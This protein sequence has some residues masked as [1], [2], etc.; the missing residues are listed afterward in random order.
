VQYIGALRSNKL[1]ILH[2]VELLGAKIKVKDAKGKETEIESG[3][4][5]E[6]LPAVLDMFTADAQ[7]T[8]PGLI[9][10]NTASAA[11]LQTIPGIDASMAE[12]I[13]ST[14]HGLTPD[15]RR[16]PA[17]I[18]QE[19]LV[20]EEVFKQAAPYLTTRTWQFSFYVVGYG[21]P[22]GRYRVLEV[23]IDTA[24]DEPVVTYLRDI[25]K[26]GLPFPLV[27]AAEE[28]VSPAGSSLTSRGVHPPASTKSS[29]LFARAKDRPGAPLT[30]APRPDRAGH[31][32]LAGS[33]AQV[34]S[35]QVTL[36]RRP[37]IT[38]ADLMRPRKNG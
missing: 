17:W 23:T 26:L 3:V 33:S 21:L 15:K 35:E 32:H 36:V 7:E 24:L 34:K 12:A 6:Q 11:V 4:G 25:T 31:E 30:A 2:P 14:R 9:N 38:A 5:K 37:L 28:S 20:S 8:V 1:T 18:F 27:P 22:S 19:D 16:S 29:S 10:V 13:V